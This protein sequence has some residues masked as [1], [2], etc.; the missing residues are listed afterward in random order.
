M[1]GRLAFWQAK[2]AAVE[3]SRTAI[4]GGSGGGGGGYDVSHFAF[5]DG[6]DEDYEEE[7]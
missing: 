3:A 2:K 5:N 6:E 1:H 4:L 7:E